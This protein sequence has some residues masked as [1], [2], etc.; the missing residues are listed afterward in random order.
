[1]DRKEMGQVFK[2]VAERRYTFVKQMEKKTEVSH[3][4]KFI[5]HGNGLSFEKILELLDKLDL[6][7]QIEDKDI[8]WGLDMRLRRMPKKLFHGERI[9]ARE[10]VAQNGFYARVDLFESPE[11]VLKFIPKPCDV[12]EIYPGRLIR[13]YF[14]VVDH[15]Y[16]LLYSF[17]EHIPAEYIVNKVTYR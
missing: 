6:T 11:M 17:N 3:I 15:P 1:M 7:F 2:E 10:F 13:K 12:Y 16:G 14:D 5:N 8:D 4:N 9:E